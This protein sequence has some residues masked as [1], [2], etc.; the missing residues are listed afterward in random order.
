MKSSP[1]IADEMGQEKY[2]AAHPPSIKTK[3]ISSVA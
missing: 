1:T 2:N 3:K